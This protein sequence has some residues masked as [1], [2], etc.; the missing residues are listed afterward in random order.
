[1]L[2][3]RSK[4][5]VSS[6]SIRLTRLFQHMFF[7]DLGVNQSLRLK[8]LKWF[9]GTIVLLIDLI[10]LPELYDYCTNK[11]KLNTRELNGEEFAAALSIFGDSIPL[12][13]VRID[14]HARLG[15]K[16]WR[17]AYVSF[18]TINIYGNMPIHLLI[19]ELVH[20]WQY[21]NYGS[22]Y[23]VHALF[24]Q[25]SEM[26]YDYGGLDTLKGVKARGGHLT[27]FNFEQQADIIRDYY[28]IKN[29]FAAQWSRATR[30]DLDSYSYYVG[31][32][33]H[34]P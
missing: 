15:P 17:F 14:Q 22:M 32:L 1:M 24:A 9:P 26:G 25:R 33:V 23:I 8:I 3:Q 28:L 13:D 29:G 5:Y 20:V 21:M 10:A 4:H 19:H 27:D 16:Q 7:S 31:Q 11:C 12:A 18:F 30:E 34:S 2:V 6:V